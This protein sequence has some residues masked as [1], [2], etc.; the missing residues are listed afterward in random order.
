MDDADLAFLTSAERT[1]LLALHELGV[2][3]LL[4]G[5]SAALLQGARGATED[6]DLWFEDVGDERIGIAARRAG[7]FWITRMQPPTLGGAIGERFDV[8]LT[9][10]GLPDFAR[11]Y[12]RAPEEDLGGVRVR[13]LPLERILL[14]KRAAHRTKDEPGVHQIEVALRVLGKL[15]EE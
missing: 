9:M 14:S 1:F 11:E 10:S 4:V 5:M 6:I 13:V 8:V 15:E 12:D 7:G 2:R 3:F